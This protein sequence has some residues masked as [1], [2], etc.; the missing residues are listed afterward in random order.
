MQG[1][2]RGRIQECVSKKSRDGTKVYPTVTLAISKPDS[3]SLDCGVSAASNGLFE[4]CM[5]MEDQLVNAV[6]N[7]REYEGRTFFDLVSVEPLAVPGSIK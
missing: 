2:F 6:I 5:K 1:L 4:K 3:G 7:I